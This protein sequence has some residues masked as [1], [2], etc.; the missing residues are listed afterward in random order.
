NLASRSTRTA[1]L[2]LSEPSLTAPT[3]AAALV[4]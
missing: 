2:A 3:L 1:N 4:K